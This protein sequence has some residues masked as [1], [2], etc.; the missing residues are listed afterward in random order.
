MSS[1]NDAPISPAK[2]VHDWQGRGTFAHHLSRQNNILFAGQPNQQALRDAP[3]NNVS[4]I[5][6]TREPAEITP[7]QLGF[8]EPATI[9][10]AGLRFLSIPFAGAELSTQHADALAHALADIPADQTA[11]IHCGSSNRVGALWALY[12]IRH[13]G[14]TL[15]EALEHARAA[16]L[17]SP[18]LAHHVRALAS[19]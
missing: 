11:L 15:D 13:R 12:L 6:S 1:L 4:T 17:T 5:I 3:A 19:S 10:D 18:P 7:D 14:L 2:P 16:G 9:N 8:D